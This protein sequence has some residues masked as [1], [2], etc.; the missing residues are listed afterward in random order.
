M[1]WF[2]KKVKAHY[3]NRDQAS[4]IYTLK[5]SGAEPGDTISAVWDRKKHTSAAQSLDTGGHAPHGIIY[6]VDI[7]DPNHCK[8]VGIE[9][10][11]NSVARGKNTSTW[12]SIIPNGLW[13]TA[14]LATQK[15]GEL[16]N[17]G[18]RSAEDDMLVGPHNNGSTSFWGAAYGHTLGH[19]FIRAS[20]MAAV[21]TFSYD[22][23]TRIKGTN[24]QLW[25]GLGERDISTT[26]DTATEGVEETHFIHESLGCNRKSDHY[27][28]YQGFAKEGATKQQKE[29]SLLKMTRAEYDKFQEDAKLADEVGAVA[30]LEV[31]RVRQRYE[32][33]QTTHPKILP[34]RVKLNGYLG[35]GE[36]DLVVK[37]TACPSYKDPSKPKEPTNPDVTP[38]ERTGLPEEDEFNKAYTEAHTHTQARIPAATGLSEIQ[39][40]VD[41]RV[42][43]A[44]AKSVSLVKEINIPV[45]IRTASDTE[46]VPL[47]FAV[48]PLVEPAITDPQE[49]TEVFDRRELY[50]RAHDREYVIKHPEWKYPSI[51][52]APTTGNILEKALEHKAKPGDPSGVDYAPGHLLTH[53]HKI[54]AHVTMEVDE[55]TKSKFYK[56]RAG[57]FITD[58][59]G[60]V[61]RDAYG[62]SIRM[63]GG[64]IYAD[65]P[66]DIIEMPGRDKVTMAGRNASMQ[67]QQDVEVVS[68]I[69]N[70]RIKAHNQLSM[71]GGAAGSSGGVL[72]ENQA[73]GKPK[74]NVEGN[75]VAS[76]GL[77]LKSP[78]YTNIQAP[79]IGVDATT[80]A[81]NGEIS[82]GMLLC[83]PHIYGT[84]VHTQNL[85]AAAGDFGGIAA[86]STGYGVPNPVVSGDKINSLWVTVDK[87]GGFIAPNI[88]FSFNSSKEYG[89]E[90]PDYEFEL[91]EPI[92]QS[93]ER[94]ANKGGMVD[95][96][97]N[98]L[99]GVSADY[100]EPYPG[101]SQLTANTFK[102]LENTDTFKTVWD[103]VDPSIKAFKSMPWLG[104]F[105]VNGGVPSEESG[106]PGT[107]KNLI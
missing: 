88:T 49:S 20:E 6:E 94:L 60:I 69:G 85:Q 55:Q 54:P 51:E 22:D 37:S 66:G 61:I 53:T 73:G 64:N 75:K 41:G 101:N 40:A 91:I 70:T 1:A 29:S 77:V 2:S 4:G 31:A 97:A 33:W 23:L 84:D 74:E 68:A 46:T 38:A 90:L 43:I 57:I 99:K 25:T 27:E 93:R 26:G 21:Q 8:I 92:W 79:N 5:L 11:S 89:L 10:L 45:P 9:P 76:L 7:S 16:L 71:L 58:D 96:V 65:C 36:V 42:R 13:T 19:A 44:S 86:R 30:R 15:V 82:V 107:P 35:H 83:C 106:E 32:Q 102:Q 105:K 87:V 14:K 63:T 24:F 80:T 50:N 17:C 62:S 28:I 39:R 47:N 59:G 18:F 95:W 56:G 81:F 34:R 3:V 12:W 78:S 104:S 72:I 48:D 52:E 67:A 103:G 98:E 100:Q